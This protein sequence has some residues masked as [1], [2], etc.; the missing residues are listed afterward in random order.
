MII[1]FDGLSDLL[2]FPLQKIHREPQNI[3]LRTVETLKGLIPQHLSLKSKKL[4]NKI[5][6]L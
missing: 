6:L 5:I 4:K 1:V 3:Q 2:Y